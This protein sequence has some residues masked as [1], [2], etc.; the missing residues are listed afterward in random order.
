MDIPRRRDDRG[1]PP[2]RDGQTEKTAV[3]RRDRRS[4]TGFRCG[5]GDE[6]VGPLA[7]LATARLLAR[8]AACVRD[9][10]PAA[11]C[12]HLSKGESVAFGDREEAE[13]RL[14][15]LGRL[16]KTR[17]VYAAPAT[18]PW[19]FAHRS[20]SEVRVDPNRD[21]AIDTRPDACAASAT[22]RVVNEVFR[23]HVFQIGVTFHGGMEA[24]VCG[25]AASNVVRPSRRRP[26]AT[27]TLQKSSRTGS[28][29]RDDASHAAA[30]EI[31]RNGHS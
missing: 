13:A 14:Q 27:P 16:V 25:R 15:W 18:N 12:P 3:P 17:L 1:V 2:R 9:G 5:A 4:E 11:S 31:S 10:A 7:T 21:F 23:R 8:S 24:I 28:R 20:R 26:P 29:P 6:R 30:A 22:G 19:G